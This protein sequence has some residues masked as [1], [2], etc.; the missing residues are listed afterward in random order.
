VEEKGGK[1]G[2]AGQEGGG[3]EKTIIPRVSPSVENVRG[4][5]EKD[6]PIMVRPKGERKGNQ[7]YDRRKAVRKKEKEKG[8]EESRPL[9][10]RRGGGK[11]GKGDYLNSFGGGP[12]GGTQKETGPS[13]LT[14]EGGK[15][16]KKKLL[17]GYYPKKK[18]PRHRET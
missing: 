11:G 10:G 2:G 9:K 4:E 1:G 16:K 15:R 13:D 8:P 18:T 14:R 6:G 3:G 5:K 17:F 12:I 7:Y